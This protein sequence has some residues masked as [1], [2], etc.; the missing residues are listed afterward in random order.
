MTLGKRRKR[1]IVYSR[2]NGKC[3]YCH[4]PIEPADMTLDHI[5]PRSRGGESTLDNLVAACAPCNGA[6]KDMTYKIYRNREAEYGS[7]TEQE[8]YGAVRHGGDG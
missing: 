7:E 2:S 1:E 4:M 8:L 6:K 3:Y 5:I